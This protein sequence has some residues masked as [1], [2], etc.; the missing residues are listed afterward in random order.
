[1]KFSLFL[2]SARARFL[3][4]PIIEETARTLRYFRYT[5]AVYR[6]PNLSFRHLTYGLAALYALGTSL[7]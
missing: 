5:Q 6:E 7:W 3:M 1:M 2:S 4:T